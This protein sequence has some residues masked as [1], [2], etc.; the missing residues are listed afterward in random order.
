MGKWEKLNYKCPGFS[1]NV[2]YIVIDYLMKV[3]GGKMGNI[4]ERYLLQMNDANFNSKILDFVRYA[5]IIE[6]C[7]F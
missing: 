2:H 3:G 7:T 1:S 4:V 6:K 5:K